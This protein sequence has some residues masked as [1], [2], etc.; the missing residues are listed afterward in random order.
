MK[1]ESDYLRETTMNPFMVLFWNLSLATYA[2]GWTLDVGSPFYFPLYAD[3]F[4]RNCFT[5]GAW[6][7]VYWVEWLASE[8]LD[9]S[10]GSE[11]V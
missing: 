6:F 1:A 7:M 8:Y 11:E 9:E 2:P 3:T 4:L 10:F 5:F